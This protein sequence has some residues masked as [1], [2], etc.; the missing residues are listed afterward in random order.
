MMRSSSSSRSGMPR[1]GDPH[2]TRRPFARSRSTRPAADVR[3][4]EVEGE[5]RAAHATNAF[6]TLQAGPLRR[7]D[8]VAADGGGDDD[9]LGIREPMARR[10][11]PSS[12]S[13]S[14]PS[15]RLRTWNAPVRVVLDRTRRSR[16]G[17]RRRRDPDAV[18]AR[19]RRI[20]CR[21]GQHVCPGDQ[22]GDRLTSSPSV[23]VR[24]GVPH[25]H[26]AQACR[27]GRA[28]ASRRSEACRGTASR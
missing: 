27:R 9:R 12:I 11:C 5:G 15:T 25:V 23:D 20:R 2:A 14:S 18:R 4:A 26:G 7:S 22:L 21:V 10:R 28:A 3:S 6:T 13:T 24:E 1:Q 19:A 17:G 8:A 16:A